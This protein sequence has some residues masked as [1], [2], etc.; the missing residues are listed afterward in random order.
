M[1]QERE[2]EFFN[3]DENR[4]D[5]EWLEQPK[6]FFRA[7]RK[8]AEARADY[9]QAK[10]N[11]K[12][13]VAEISHEIIDNPSKFGVTKTTEKV[14]ENTVLLQTK[15][16]VANE[17]ELETQKKVFHLQAVVE[18]MDHRKKALE[19]L[20]DLRLADYFSSPRAPRV[21]RER[22]EDVSKNKVNDR[23]RKSLNRE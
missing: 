18:A 8:L 7:A 6:M 21:E 16:K 1:E 22:M 3:L 2:F 9:E 23:V 10:S 12:L 20:V 11:K 17:E 15:Y 19:K 4:L 14:V 13:V 5:E